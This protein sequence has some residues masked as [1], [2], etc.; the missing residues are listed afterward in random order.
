[1]PQ[2]AS[3]W[4]LKMAQKLRFILARYEKIELLVRVR[5]YQKGQDLEVDDALK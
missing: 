2:I 3:S 4:H 1:M 5:E